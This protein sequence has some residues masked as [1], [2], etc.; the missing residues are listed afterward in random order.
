M[1]M[2]EKD[3]ERLEAVMEGF[4]FKDAQKIISLWIE[5]APQNHYVK[6]ISIPTVDE[7]KVVGRD[8]LKDVLTEDLDFAG[9]RFLK[10]YKI[11]WEDPREYT[12]V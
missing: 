2:K 10:A 11:R 1:K 5:N 6:G 9:T 3:Y 12:L 7:L 8:L 4:N